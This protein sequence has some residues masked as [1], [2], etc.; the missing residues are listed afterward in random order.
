MCGDKTTGDARKPSN[1]LRSFDPP[2]TGVPSFKY[3]PSY[4]MTS[5]TGHFPSLI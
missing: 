5:L 3:P 1:L 2:K 4:G